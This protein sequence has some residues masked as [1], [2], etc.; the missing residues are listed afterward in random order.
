MSDFIGDKQC[1]T[2]HHACDCREEHFKQLQAELEK[3][4]AENKRLNAFMEC[5]IED[6]EVHLGNVDDKIEQSNIKRFIVDIKQN[7]S[8]P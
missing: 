1:V 5:V 4:K 3:V 6:L 8:K 2:H 7:L